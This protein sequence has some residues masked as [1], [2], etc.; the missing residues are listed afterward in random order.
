MVLLNTITLALERHGIQEEERQLLD[1]FDQYFT[2]TFIV[3][4]CSKVLAI[5][6]QKYLMDK[7]NWLDGGVVMLSVFEMSYKAALD[8]DSGG[9]NL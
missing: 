2:F 5:G 9:V 8:S 6:I 4:L 7:M 3:E 1:T